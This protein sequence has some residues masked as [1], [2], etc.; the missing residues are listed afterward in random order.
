M[1][2]PKFMCPACKAQKYKQLHPKGFLFEYPNGKYEYHI[3]EC[4]NCH[5]KFKS[6]K[7][8]E[9]NLNI[10][11]NSNKVSASTWNSEVRY[12]H[13]IEIDK[14]IRRLPQKSRILDVGCFTG[15][16]LS[17]HKNHDLYG[18]EINRE[19]ATHAKAQ[20]IKILNETLD[21]PF[22]N[23]E[24]K[25]DIITMVDVF[26]HLDN[27][28]ETVEYLMSKLAM[29]G[30]LIIMTGA[31][32][33]LFFKFLGP[34]YWY[35]A[36]EDHISF[37]TKPY[38]RKLL[39]NKKGFTYSWRSKRHYH[40][41]LKNSFKEII[42]SFLWRFILPNGQYKGYNLSKILTLNFF[43]KYTY[44]LTLTF[45]KDHAYIIIERT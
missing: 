12:P 1:A 17:V 30:K 21:N 42:W 19:A 29:G 27:P 13:E 16:L 5:L 24:L 34:S 31:A 33:S 44:P 43:S 8:L 4:E 18:I 38:L 14:T 20:G 7:F 28:T 6:S 22:Q 3:L 2:T 26:E 11:Y 25:F 40:T 37:I 45:P 39:S 41:A 10:H 15:K 32:D 36:I 35:Y 23:I 9:F